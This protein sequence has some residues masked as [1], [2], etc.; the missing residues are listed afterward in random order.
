MGLP[1]HRNFHQV[2]ESIAQRKIRLSVIEWWT[3]PPLKPAIGRSLHPDDAQ[4]ASPGVV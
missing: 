3:Q 1:F 2:L 4:L